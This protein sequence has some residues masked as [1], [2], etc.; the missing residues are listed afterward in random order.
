MSA[1]D[2]LLLVILV[3]ASSSFTSIGLIADACVFKEKEALLEFKKA[4]T[5]DHEG[6]LQ[7][8]QLD[9]EGSDCCRWD[10]VHCSNLTGH[11][12]QL[13]LGDYRGRGG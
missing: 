11:V 12:V 5:I 7:S 10:H 13:Q 9:D 4:I 1:T 3:V 6:M 2:F 8:W